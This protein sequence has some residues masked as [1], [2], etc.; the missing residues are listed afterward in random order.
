MSNLNFP[1]KIRHYEFGAEGGLPLL[2]FHGFPGSGIESK[3]LHDEAKRNNYWIFSFDRPGYGGT[4]AVENFDRKTYL[5]QIYSFV[6]EKTNSQKIFVVGVSGGGPIASDFA[7]EFHNDIHKLV[8]VCALAGLKSEQVLNSYRAHVRMALILFKTLP[9][10]I[11]QS[12]FALASKRFKTS[13][14]FLRRFVTQ[15]PEPDKEAFE[16]ILLRGT[17][18]EAYVNS[19]AQQLKGAI[20]DVEHYL[21]WEPHE[22]L[23]RLVSIHLIHGT[24]DTIVPIDSLH[25]FKKR[26]P[27]ASTHIF[28]DGHF[29]LPFHQRNAVFNLAT[30][31]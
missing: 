21:N 3:L 26:W 18:R 22:G 29:S 28:V 19:R 12:L 1:F 20:F 5:K 24:L 31:P 2:Y 17:M 15:L 14:D 23:D 11:R 4:P 8:L 27:L 7:K 10:N 25:E 13:E 9:K 30:Q 16:H 6:R